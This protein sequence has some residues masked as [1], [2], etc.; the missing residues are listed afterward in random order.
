LKSKITT[1]NSITTTPTKHLHTNAEQYGRT[2]RTGN[3]T[4]HAQTSKPVR[5][6]INVKYK[7]FKNLTLLK[8][9][10]AAIPEVK[11]FGTK[12]VFNIGTIIAIKKNQ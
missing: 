3:N 9:Q 10:T 12:F 1:S 8:D 2:N 6:S 11:N 5:T 7:Q 4:N